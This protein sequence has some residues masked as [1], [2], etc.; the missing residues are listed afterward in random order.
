MKKYL[1]PLLRT[2]NLG[3]LVW[4]AFALEC[5]YEMHV[6]AHWF[7]GNVACQQKWNTNSLT[8]KGNPLYNFGIQTPFI[9]NLSPAFLISKYIESDKKVVFQIL[10][11]AFIIYFLLRALFRNA[12]INLII[13]E[14]LSFISSVIIWI[15]SI[16]SNALTAQI[17]LGLYW[18]EIAIH[19]LA[20]LY[21]IKKIDESRK[22]KDS[23]FWCGLLGSLVFYSVATFPAFSAYFFLCNALGVAF[24][25]LTCE[26]KTKIK[27]SLIYLSLAI[28]F[29]IIKVPSFLHYLV[30]YTR[31]GVFDFYSNGSRAW[32]LHDLPKQLPYL[33]IFTRP[34][35]GNPFAKSI[36]LICLSTCVYHVAKKGK[37][38]TECAYLLGAWLTGFAYTIKWLFWGGTFAT[39]YYFELVSS[40]LIVF[41]A[42]IAMYN[43]LNILVCNNKSAISMYAPIIIS[44]FVYIYS[45]RV[46][47]LTSKRE[48]FSKWPPSE[49]E[50]STSIK[51]ISGIK[52]NGKYLGKCLVLLDTNN[53]DSSSFG[54][55][56]DICANKI[57]TKI[58][59]DLLIDLMQDNVPLLNEYGQFI[60]PPFL[61]LLCMAFYDSKDPIARA[62]RCPRVYN[63]AMARLLGVSSVV[64][65]SPIPEELVMH[66][67]MGDHDL[68]LYKVNQANM[69]TYS[70]TKTQTYDSLEEIYGK[71]KNSGID[72]GKTVFTEE[73]I[74]QPLVPANVQ[75]VIYERGPVLKIKAQSNGCSLIVL[76]FDFSYCLRFSGSGHAKVIPVNLSCTGLLIHGDI[77]GYI[78]YQ[79]SIFKNLKNRKKDYDRCFRLGIREYAPGHLF[80]DQP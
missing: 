59:S 80:Y 35:L 62:A 43:A 20:A 15:P 3:L 76:P 78:D 18:Q 6:D 58:G 17:T 23:I 31:E 57:R 12:G 33:S 30:S 40:P 25:I 77:N 9:A 36:G 51:R 7:Q 28:L 24:V 79:Y 16:T 74:L 66:E 72:F 48:H 50:W 60:S 55:F 69:G 54:A 65:D 19:N 11:E 71:I 38:R 56:Y 68:F 70:P 63:A 47:W 41:I 39:C 2:I 4:M 29:V 44:L 52:E 75:S 61:S 42:I 49:S 64:T 27:L 67:K 46:I 21:L 45:A 8:L 37:L 32:W 14:V 22:T 73:N 1:L 53:K 10:A 34:D 26:R 13:S 5:D